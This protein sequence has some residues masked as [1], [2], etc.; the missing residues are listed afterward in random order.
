VAAVAG[1][2]V[3]D[4]PAGAELCPASPAVH[5]MPAALVVVT[6]DAG[7]GRRVGLQDPG[8]TLDDDAAG[9]VTRDEGAAR[10]AR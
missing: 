2:P 3:H 8:T 5:A 4:D 7:P 10:A 6:H 1:H 9:L